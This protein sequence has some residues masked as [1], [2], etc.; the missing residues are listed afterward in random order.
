MAL[1]LFVMALSPGC[2]S[3]DAGSSLGSTSNPVRV[4]GFQGEFDYFSRLRCADETKPHVQS[5]E[6]R[7]RGPGGQGLNGYR[8][9][10][11]YLNQEIQIYFDR[12]RPRVAEAEPV[13]GFTLAG[14]P[15]SH[16]AFWGKR[17]GMPPN[18]R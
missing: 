9:R 2:A 10:C 7:R 3:V 11:I 16:Q 6:R 13:S 5:L 12:T 8:V 1:S 18:R 4:D 17:Q 14:S 15:D